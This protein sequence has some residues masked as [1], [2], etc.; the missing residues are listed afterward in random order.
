MTYLEVSQSVN[1]IAGIELRTLGLVKLSSF[2]VPT[3][4][5]PVQNL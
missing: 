5:L 2:A 4:N 3:P 1:S